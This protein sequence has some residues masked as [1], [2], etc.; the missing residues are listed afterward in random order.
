MHACIERNMLYNMKLKFRLDNKTHGCLFR[1][2]GIG[3]LKVLCQGL[4]LQ[5][6]KDNGLGILMGCRILSRAQVL[7][8]LKIFKILKDFTCFSKLLILPSHLPLFG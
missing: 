3:N 1:I 6:P 2:H 8:I 5:S 7:K 4:V